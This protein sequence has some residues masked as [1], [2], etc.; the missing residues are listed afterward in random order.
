MAPIINLT[1]HLSPRVPNAGGESGK[2]WHMPV[3]LVRTLDADR[4]TLWSKLWHECEVTTT[5]LPLL[6]APMWPRDGAPWTDWRRI[7]HRDTAK[8][9]GTSPTTVGKVLRLLMAREGLETRLVPHAHDARRSVTEYR[10]AAWLY[11]ADEHFV[12]VPFA[13]ILSGY[14][15]ALPGHAARHLL[16]ALEALDPI[17]DAPAF[18][19]KFGHQ[20]D[21]DEERGKEVV[22]EMRD[23][24]WRSDSQLSRLTG[25]HRKH[26]AHL[27]PLL[28][29]HRMRARAA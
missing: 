24:A 16:L 2:F 8:K 3:R 27:L 15:A 9:L 13:R 10:L 6:A 28:E 4:E 21:E 12:R 29:R 14:W 20:R 17:Q 26:V 25:I 11:A 19:R 1:A 22:D 5:V 18:V 7:T 23:R